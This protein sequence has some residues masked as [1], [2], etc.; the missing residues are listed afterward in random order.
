M[1]HLG[2]GA[3][4]AALHHG[5]SLDTTMGMTPTGGLVMSTRSGDLDPG[6]VLYLLRE[7]GLSVEQVNILLNKKAE[8]DVPQKDTGITALWIASQEGH[9]DIV[10]LLLEDSADVNAVRT[11]DG[12][13]ALWQASMQGRT[14]VVRLLLEND[15]DY[16]AWSSH[17]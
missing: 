15:A 10:K 2:N 6:V 8:V 7:K 4:M 14:E 11:T 5:K 1:A 3:S 16:I 17:R 9:T 12:V 13:S